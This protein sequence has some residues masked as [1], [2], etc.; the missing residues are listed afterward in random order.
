M[1]LLTG[2]YFLLASACLAQS[3]LP[4]PAPSDPTGVFSDVY[5]TVAQ[6][7]LKGTLTDNSA[8]NPDYWANSRDFCFSQK[9]ERPTDKEAQRLSQIGGITR[10][11]ALR[12]ISKTLP[13]YNV[14]TTEGAQQVKRL[15]SVIDNLNG[16]TAV[17]PDDIVDLMDAT[18]PFM[19]TMEAA[20]QAKGIKI[21][22]PAHSSVSY[23]Y[24]PHCLQVDAP[25]VGVDAAK[26]VHRAVGIARPVGFYPAS[27][28]IPKEAQ[29]LYSGIINYESTHPNSRMLVHTLLWGI[30][31]ADLK[32]PPINPTE[33]QIALLNA[34][35]PDG[36]K[37]YADYVNLAQHPEQKQDTTA[38]NPD[39]P[40]AEASLLS[41]ASANHDLLKHHLDA[42]TVNHGNAVPFN[43]ADTATILKQL[44]D[45]GEF[46]TIELQ[47]ENQTV[48][49]STPIAFSAKAS[50]PN[51]KYQ[52]RFNGKDIA[53]ATTNTLKLTASST[54]VGVYQLIVS[55]ESATV[56]SRQV[57]LKLKAQTNGSGGLETAGLPNGSNDPFHSDATNSAFETPSSNNEAQAVETTPNTIGIPASASQTPAGQGDKTLLNPGVFGQGSQNVLN[58]GKV[59]ITN[60]SDTPYGF[61]P[62]T[63]IVATPEPCQPS[64]VGP[65]GMDAPATTPS[66]ESVQKAT[67]E[68]NKTA[69]LLKKA[70]N[71]GVLNWLV[72]D[73]DTI[74]IEVENQALQLLLR[75][76]PG[77]SSA[78][79]L[80]EFAENEDAFTGKRLT[81]LERASAALGTVAGVVGFGG[82]ATDAEAAWKLLNAASSDTRVV[83]TLKAGVLGGLKATEE[84]G[85]NRLAN[86][87]D[88]MITGAKLG[89]A[90][91]DLMK[92]DTVAADE[93]IHDVVLEETG[94][95]LGE[96]LNTALI[97][98]LSKH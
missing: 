3:T 30:R 78:I 2:C 16:K 59:T 97:R 41:V 12:G 93:K 37:K 83:T 65:A 31:G 73:G 40:N 89:E 64:S 34:A 47:P 81:E 36:A 84:F 96:K 75:N 82:A 1:K 90:V 95:K 60:T 54:T 18:L 52:W 61:D 23:A 58:D 72:I 80:W 85:N 6:E 55:N 33:E 91:S 20:A 51:L 66:E 71:R 29:E 57:L 50:G 98:V 21:T 9:P 17:S 62:T 22:V 32:P 63:F 92:G 42:I 7:A 25:A 8:K 69:D 79:S 19:R 38:K 43:P 44:T 45:P 88:M 74:S 35:V 46:P 53:N 68:V 67:D 76:T 24:T 10:V 27:T 48:P 28:L 5:K 77:I 94:E 14:G 56:K 87:V 13:I 49:D 86:G 4:E 39:D 26:R 15:D 11:S 70:E